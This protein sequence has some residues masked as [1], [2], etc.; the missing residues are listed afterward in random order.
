MPNRES[1]ISSQ[2]FK[3]QMYSNNLLRFDTED[4][5]TLIIISTGREFLT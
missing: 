5:L 3:L 1:V 4:L 2:G